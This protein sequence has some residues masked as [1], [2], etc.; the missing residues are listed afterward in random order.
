MSDTADPQTIPLPPEVQALVLAAVARRV[1]EQDKLTRAEFS[2][3]YFAGIKRTFRS[4][5][6]QAPLGYVQRTDPDPDWR[7]TDRA[8]LEEHLA[9]FPGA[10]ETVHE[11]H[12]PS[13]TVELD[14]FDE[15]Y[16]VLTEHAPHMLHPRRRVRPDAV[17]AAVE[18]S[19]ATGKAAAPGIGLVRPGGQLRVVAHKD[20]GVAV[21]RMVAAGVIRWDGAAP[22]L[23][24]AGGSS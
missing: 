14:E 19:R 15:L 24:R 21:E 23:P 9:G 18:Q 6:D 3:H 7:I 1:A 11:V 17:E 4:P 16:V 5:L 10:V 8:A 2:G 20:A 12:T 13:V 22:A